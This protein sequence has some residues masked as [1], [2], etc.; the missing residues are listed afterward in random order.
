MNEHQDRLLAV[1][2]LTGAASLADDVYVQRILAEGT[3]RITQSV[4]CSGFLV[5]LEDEEIVFD[6]A[7]WAEGV[8]GAPAPGLR[9]RL[10]DSILVGL[11][12]GERTGAWA[13]I[14][15]EGYDPLPRSKRDTPVRALIGTRFRIGRVDYALVFAAE[16]VHRFDDDDR[17]F[18]EVLASLCTG[19]LQW[20]R[21]GALPPAAGRDALTGIGT[22]ETLRALAGAALASGNPHAV[23]VLDVDGLHRVNDTL[24]FAAGDTILVEV[25]AALSRVGGP[26]LLARLGGDSFGI[27]LRD[28]ADAADAEQRVRAYLD[29]FAT[30]FAIDGH[31]DGRQ[32]KLT[33]SAGIALAPRDGRS[34]D[35]LFARADAAC[36][37]AKEEGRARW[38]FFER[39]LLDR[40]AEAQRMHADLLDALLRDELVLHFQPH[41]DLATGTIVGAEALVRWHHPR[42]GLLMPADFLPVAQDLGLMHRIGLWVMEQTVEATG[43]WRAAQ[44]GFRA[45]FN[46][47]AFELTDPNFLA[48][49]L[50][51]DGAL[52]GVGVE[53]TQTVALRDA[54][55]TTRALATLRQA[56]LAIA[57]HDFGIGASSL[58]RL[59]R[60]RVDMLKID[61]AVVA[62]LP[63]D[64]HDVAVVD[65]MVGIA[66]RFGYELLAQG[67]ESRAQQRALLRAGCRWGQ[68]FLFG[69]PCSN[70]DFTRLLEGRP[71]QDAVTAC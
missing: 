8:R 57:L 11:M 44:P 38:R 25:A 55:A 14:H 31:D 53:I 42:R 15:R 32:V 24:G 26:D 61:A 28:V 18:V 27:V 7:C 13:D 66:D 47:S 21:A 33:A 50:A 9:T 69:R 17:A 70:E 6:L 2:A 16:R 65:A 36:Y 23:V 51:F 62:G 3:R 71:P 20:S 49:V 34:F 4:P 52:E 5:H 43:V 48:Q 37:E 63:E 58:A 10:E 1:T 30:P 67:V 68:G 60:V 19:R 45:W 12:R 29:V 54:A 56:G 59:K 46:L 22:R 35:E 41:V 64:A 39:S 40:F